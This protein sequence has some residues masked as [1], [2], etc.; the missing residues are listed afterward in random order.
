[1]YDLTNWL[2]FG[3]DYRRFF[4]HRDRETPTVQRLT[5]GLRLSFK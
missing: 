2:G 4:V 5:A 1:M 3:A